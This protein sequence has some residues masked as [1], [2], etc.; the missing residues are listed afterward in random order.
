M[1]D[2]ILIVPLIVK[3]PSLNA[4]DLP[5]GTLVS[6][7][8][9]I[10]DTSYAQEVFVGFHRRDSDSMWMC[11]RYIERDSDTAAIRHLGASDK[12]VVLDERQCLR[13]SPIAGL[14]PWA[15]HASIKQDVILKCYAGLEKKIR[16]CDVV[17]V[18]G[19]L[20]RPADETQV[21]HV[22]QITPTHVS[23]LVSTST[24]TDFRLQREELINSF[25]AVLGSY[26]AAEMVLLSLLSSMYA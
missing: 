13:A 23:D 18:F 6:C 3:V 12:N 17:R 7:A 15:A 5:P 25:K 26:D 10:Q 21:I 14:T 11:D 8:C 2:L 16:V 9:M 20:E 4:Q 1:I 22:L 24:G 19:I